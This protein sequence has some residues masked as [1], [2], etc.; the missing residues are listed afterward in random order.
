MTSSPPRTPPRVPRVNRQHSLSVRRRVLDAYA[1]RGDWSTVAFHNGMP[2]STAYSL[3][4]RGT[5]TYRPRGG[6]RAA[7]TR[8]T[9]EATQH[10]EMYLEEDASMTL[11]VMQERLRDDCDVDV[12]TS[13]IARHLDGM[14]YTVKQLR[15]EKNTMNSDRNKAL[16][17]DYAIAM[18]EHQEAGTSGLYFVDG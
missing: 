6:A 13:T 11:A 17:R 12:H 16:R 8:M 18:R 3:V 2:L 5:P 14:M 10:L 7:R 15:M 9:V 1:K 4:G